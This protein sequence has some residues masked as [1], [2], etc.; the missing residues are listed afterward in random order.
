[1]DKPNVLVVLHMS[2]LVV[3]VF[4]ICQ[5]LS[6]QSF[7]VKQ[8]GTVDKTC[9][10]KDSLAANAFIPVVKQGETRGILDRCKCTYLSSVYDG[11][12]VR[13]WYINHTATIK[14]IRLVAIKPPWK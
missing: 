14:R 11:N 7:H 4:N 10:S 2:T 12:T 3:K 1:M 5:Y 6:A 13:Y 8:D 9:S